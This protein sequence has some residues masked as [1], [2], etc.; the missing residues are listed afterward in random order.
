MFG[1]RNPHSNITL[2]RTKAEMEA[3]RAMENSENN[4]HEI[5]LPERPRRTDTQT[6]TPGGESAN[7][8]PQNDEGPDYWKMHIM[9]MKET[10]DI[11]A[12]INHPMNL[13][14]VLTHEWLENYFTRLKLQPAFLPRRGELVL[15][16]PK[17]DG[18]FVFNPDNL[19]FMMK[20]EDGA[21]VFPEWR[22]GVITKT[23]ETDSSFL[24]IITPYSID[25][26]D[27]GVPSDPRA[28]RVETIP[29]PLA[30]TKDVPVESMFVPLQCIKP[31][32]TYER[33]IYGIPRE[34]THPSISFA[35]TTMASYSL[36]SN[37]NFKGTWPNAR[38]FSRGMFVGTEL[39]ALH[40]TVRLKPDGVTLDNLDQRQT[41]F[42]VDYDLADVMVIEKIWLELVD[43]ND[44]PKDPQI[45]KQVRPRLAGKV[46]TRQ[47]RRL[48]YPMQFAKDPL[49]KLTDDEVSSEFYQIGMGGYGDWYA[50]A[51]RKT[52][53]I[54]PA[55]VLGRC[56]EPEA[57]TLA[58]GMLDLDYDI[59]GVLNGR[60]Y[61]GLVDTRMAEQQTWFW[62][63]CRAETLGLTTVNG[64]DVGLGA[65]QRLRPER[66]QALFRIAS[67]GP[68]SDADIR[69]AGL[70]R[71][72]GRPPRQ[73]ER[74]RNSS[75]LVATGLGPAVSTTPDGVNQD[76][77]E[78][79]SEEG[80]TPS[81]LMADYPYRVEPSDEAAEEW[82]EGYDEEYD[83]EEY[84]EEEGNEEGMD[85]DQD[86]GEAPVDD[87]ISMISQAFIH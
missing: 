25:Q 63:N 81:E 71:G 12:Q 24:D 42:P 69:T 46:Y 59:H 45:A 13:D 75:L 44:D 33:Y 27:D 79:D 21:L 22:A 68:Y 84:Y 67:G 80:L 14:W 52:C 26:T 53:V 83:E 19:S 5:N 48:E 82:E 31:F 70:N 38:I 56:Y 16:A 62:S 72:A 34:E 37:I 60:Y 87:D 64:F 61:S 86:D 74:L 85:E 49:V 15:W 3:A 40:D 11:D 47:P 1:K 50:V 76:S 29:D 43:C 20:K 18:P 78:V 51:G 6:L 32:N 4:H 36:L 66:W 58:F 73:L 9:K 39:V 7:Y 57:A 54:S 77:E 23:P 30:P 65:P 41:G 35:L 8:Q 55:M 28:F 17:L 2:G 10:G